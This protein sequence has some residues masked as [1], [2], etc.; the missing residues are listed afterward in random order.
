LVK[1]RNLEQLLSEIDLVETQESKL[2]TDPM[3]ITTLHRYQIKLQEKQ[4]LMDL[5]AAEQQE[6]HDL[7]EALKQDMSTDLEYKPIF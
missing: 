2:P 4:R 1:E 6:N 5:L 7:I 3:Q